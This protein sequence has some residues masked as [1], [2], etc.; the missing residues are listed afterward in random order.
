MQW[1]IYGFLVHS[2]GIILPL[3]SSSAL[4]SAVVFSVRKAMLLAIDKINVSRH[5]P[6]ILLFCMYRKLV[7]FCV[8]N[9]FVQGVF[10]SCPLY[11]WYIS[12]HMTC[13][14]FMFLANSESFLIKNNN[15]ITVYSSG[16][17]RGGARGASPPPPPP[18]EDTRKI[19]MLILACR[20]KK[21]LS[22]EFTLGL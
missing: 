14:I 2:F 9:I 15:Q 1:R 19:F 12:I 11:W 13:L 20:H 8:R 6:V 22:E 16:G 4:H 18:M 7:N 21:R 3:T 17:S 10:N 5:D